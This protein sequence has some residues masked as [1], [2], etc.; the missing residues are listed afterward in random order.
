[1]TTIPLVTSW[2]IVSAVPE[3]GLVLRG[4]DTAVRVDGSLS[5]LTQ[6]GRISQWLAAGAL[7]DDHRS[8]HCW[9]VR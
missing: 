9:P 7:N 5:A 8:L 6:F 4:S 2:S 1:M 3:G